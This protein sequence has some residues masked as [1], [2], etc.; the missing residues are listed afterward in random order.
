MISFGRILAQADIVLRGH[1]LN[2]VWRPR[3]RRREV[4]GAVT[5]QAVGRYVDR[6]ILPPSPDFTQEPATGSGQEEK[7][8]SIWLQGEDNAP[9]IVRACWR[10]VRTHCRQ[11]LV[12]K[13]EA[14][15]LSELD[16]P[17]YVVSKYKAGRISR[18]HFSDICRVE[19]LYRYGG[20]WLDATDFV[21]ADFPKWLQDEDFFIYMSGEDIGGAYAFVQNCFF[22]SRRANYILGAWRA[23]I[24]EY[25]KHEDSV[26][27]Y[28]VHQLLLWRVV[29]RDH[30]AAEL[31]AA[32]P[33]ISQNATHMLWFG[34]RDEPF[35]KELFDSLTSGAL[36]QKT[37][38]KSSSARCPVP[39]SFAEKM[40]GMYL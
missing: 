10:S 38:Y 34:H 16:L 33:K 2:W 1:V 37:E 7:I 27:D 8:Y 21:T 40:M 29:S 6:Y 11:E 12:I 15:L 4:R 3:M 13:D 28:F 32:M 24:F 30:K 20:I 22:R 26:I 17:D 14:Q 5:R 9:A 18:A 36:F 19:L 23:A 25:W 31:F 39:G 35:D